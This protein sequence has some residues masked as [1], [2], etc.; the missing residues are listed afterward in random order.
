MSDDDKRVPSGSESG[1]GTASESEDEQPNR[2]RSTIRRVSPSERRELSDG[3]RSSRSRS[4][5]RSPS[6]SPDRRKRR[7]SSEEKPIVQ[8]TKAEREK[9]QQQQ[10]MKELLTTRTGGAYIPPAKLRLMQEQ[11]TDKASPAFQ[12]LAWEA[13][14]KSINGLINKVNSPNIAVIVRELFAENIV[15]GRGLLCQSIMQAQTASPTFTHVY[16]ALASIINT[17]FPDTIMLLIH[18]LLLNFRRGFKRN[19]KTRCMSSTRFI[20]HLF[21][22][23]ALHEVLP[24]EILHLLLKNPTDDS[25]EVTITFLR[26]CGQKLCELTPL[27]VSSIFRV[28]REILHES[29]LDKRTLYMIEVLCQVHKDGFKDNPAVIEE[30]DLVEE[31]DQHTHQVFIDEKLDGKE[32][33]NVFKFDPEFEK[34]ERE[35]EA[36]KKSLLEG[37]DESSDD[38]EKGSDESSSDSSDDSEGE[39]DTSA[40][41][42]DKTETNLT[43][44]RRTIYLT[45]QSSLDFEETVHKLMKLNLKPGHEKELCHMVNDCCAQQRTYEKFYGLLA[46]RLCQ[47]KREYIEPFVNIFTES[48]TNCH[49]FEM[50]KLRN[51]SKL[52]AHLLFTDAIG[53]EVLSV[54]HLNEHETTS[55]SRIYIKLLFQVCNISTPLI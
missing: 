12:R 28:L 35:Y 48:Y 25:I 31:E 53:W 55:S 44:L 30:L 10:Q 42:L 45:I 22:Q 34:H 33:L 36:I 39:E 18:R 46:Q 5:S 49:R 41:I 47:L 37:D 17:K 3:E 27:G 24:L 15:R 21:N 20:A 26:E 29:K 14:K 11:I 50:P 51:V 38:E 8:E 7:K 54:I 40:P 23:H 6:P 43:D 19:D 2:L 52:F 13:L 1:S 9:K 4:V 32:I 16:A